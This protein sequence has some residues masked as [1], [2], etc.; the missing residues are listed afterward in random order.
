MPYYSFKVRS[1]EEILIASRLLTIGEGVDVFNK[2]IDDL[3]EFLGEL[4]LLGVEVLECNQLDSLE[5]IFPSNFSLLDRIDAPDALLSE[6][7]QHPSE[8]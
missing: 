2:A 6:G 3:P 7:E 4:K 5:A 1:T 8:T